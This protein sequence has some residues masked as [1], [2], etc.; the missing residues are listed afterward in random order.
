L[1]ALL[2]LLGKKARIKC[3]YCR[4]TKKKLHDMYFSLNMVVVIK[5]NIKNG[6]NENACKILVKKPWVNY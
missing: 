3:K 2:D 1:E 5:Q 4:P 6:K